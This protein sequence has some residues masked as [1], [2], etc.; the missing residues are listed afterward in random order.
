M[1]IKDIDDLLTELEDL[2]KKGNLDEAQAIQVKIDAILS[3]SED[4][5]EFV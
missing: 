5:K 2:K 1:K 3:R 4:D